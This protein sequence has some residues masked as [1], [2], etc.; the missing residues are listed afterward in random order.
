M[1]PLVRE[2]NE[3]INDDAMWAKL[4][5]EILLKTRSADWEVRLA[6]LQ[7]VE[8]MFE[9]MRERYL[10]ILNDTIPFLSELLEDE[11]EQIEQTA[12]SI[13]KQIE[14]LTGESINDYLKWSITFAFSPLK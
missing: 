1:K 3:R 10:V 8:H 2:L 6:A 5:Y 12:Q 13:V 9:S 4:N 14:S 7:V 11:H